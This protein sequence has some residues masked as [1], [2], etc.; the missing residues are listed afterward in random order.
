[1]HTGYRVLG[2]GIRDARAHLLH[3]EPMMLDAEGRNRK[4]DR[5]RTLGSTSLLDTQFQITP[6]AATRPAALPRIRTRGPAGRGKTFEKKRRLPASLPWRW[7]AE[8]VSIDAVPRVAAG[9]RF[10]ATIQV[11]N[12]GSL[13][14]MPY[15]GAHLKLNLGNHL[16][17]AHGNLVQYERDFA[18]VL[19]VV[20]P[21]AMTMFHVLIQAPMSPGAFVFEW[22]MISEGECWFA[23]AGGKSLSHTLI[24]DP[25]VSNPDT[26]ARLDVR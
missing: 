7:K 6:D 10:V 15:N 17:D 13:A 3:L 25:A 8:V 21:G 11:K 23:D 14:W 5:Y 12:T 16:R 19:E 18:P 24:V 1:V 4:I 20:P 2:P 26:Q 22:D 9:A